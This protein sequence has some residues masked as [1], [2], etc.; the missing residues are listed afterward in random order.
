VLRERKIHEHRAWESLKCWNFILL[1]WELYNSHFKLGGK[2]QS[3][4]S[5]LWPGMY[6]NLETVLH[7]HISTFPQPPSSKLCVVPVLAVGAL[8]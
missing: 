1:F 4:N 8:Y 2:K 6:M 7:T 5:F 3:F